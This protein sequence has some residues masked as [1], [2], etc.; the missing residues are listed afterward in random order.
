M[1]TVRDILSKKGNFVASVDQN[2]TV[3]EAAK[4]MNDLRIGAVVVTDGGQVNGIF[5]ERD[6]LT[7][8]VAAQRD[9]TTTKVGE[10][11][12]RRVAV[13]H[14]DTTVEECR[15][16]MTRHR[17]RHLP[18]VEDNR[19]VGIITSGDVLALEIHAQQTT[20]EFMH[21]YLYGMTR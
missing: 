18:V 15:S 20:I 10:V 9:P 12:T 19:L 16:V 3:L 21:Q 4:L 14:P 2:A 8:V 6:I 5:S 7:R 17:V 1:A 13:C 11:M